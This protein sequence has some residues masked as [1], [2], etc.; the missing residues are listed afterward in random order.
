VPFFEQINVE[1][2]E[3]ETSDVELHDG[4]HIR[5]RKTDKGYDP[6]NKGQALD[7]LRKCQESNEFLTGLIYINEQ[8]P[9]FLTILNTIDS[10][11][12]TLP[13][14]AVQPSADDLKEIMAELM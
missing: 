14:E 2:N 8:K 12:A 11:L 13:Q 4:S 1:Y 9:D 7:T 3:G 10:P 6:T 5:L